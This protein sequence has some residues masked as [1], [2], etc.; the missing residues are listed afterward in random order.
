MT[1]RVTRC[2]DHRRS[3]NPARGVVVQERNAR[4]LLGEGH[5]PFPCRY[6]GCTAVLAARIRDR[7]AGGR[8]CDPSGSSLSFSAAL[9]SHYRLRPV[10]AQ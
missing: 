1:T 9:R 8:D 10:Q 5:R 4:L 2:P 7:G 3:S 6:A